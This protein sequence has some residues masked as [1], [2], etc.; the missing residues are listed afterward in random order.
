[1]TAPERRPPGRPRAPG[2]D[3]AILRAALDL[4]IEHGVEGTSIERVAKAAGVG[5]LTVYRRWSG[6]E[7]LIAAAVEA[8]RDDPVDL[9][10]DTP[11]AAVAW[12]AAAAQAE[13]IVQPRFRAMVARVLGTSASHP[14]IMAAY[15]THYVEPRRAALRPLI[16]RALAEGALP[17][18]TDPDVLMD[19][20]AGAVLYRLARPG[21]LD[22]ATMRR[23]L[24]DVYAQAGLERPRPA[25]G[26]QSE[27]ERGGGP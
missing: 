8:A 9:P 13:H 4:F 23:Y 22:A 24:E 15:W 3:A 5:K 1:M 20:M 10:A 25:P 14:A 19:M 6:K 18:H 26:E 16:E 12:G 27:P 2:A 17:A 11:L 7:E 21:P